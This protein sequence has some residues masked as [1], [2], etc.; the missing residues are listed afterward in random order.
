MSVLWFIVVGALVI[1]PLFKLLP[2]YG[3]NPWWAVVA[4]LPVGLIILLWMMASR[5]DE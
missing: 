4:I 5:A 2:K 3:L 1:V